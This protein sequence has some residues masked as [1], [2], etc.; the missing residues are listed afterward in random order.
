[1]AALRAAKNLFFFVDGLTQ[2]G[3]APDNRHQPGTRGA[4]LTRNETAI[5]SHGGIIPPE[6]SQNFVW[7]WSEMGHFIRTMFN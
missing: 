1:M 2:A 5:P 3:H 4:L 6:T 7:N